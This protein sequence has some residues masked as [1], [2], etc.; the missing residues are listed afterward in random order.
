MKR[1]HYNNMHNAVTDILSGV[2]MEDAGN[3]IRDYDTV[4]NVFSV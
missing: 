1:I 3:K 2:I 4:C